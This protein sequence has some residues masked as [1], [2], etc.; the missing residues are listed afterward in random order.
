[1]TIAISIG[2]LTIALIGTGFGVYVMLKP[3][4]YEI[5]S[6]YESDFEDDD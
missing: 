1:M 5:F 4:I 3:L 2:I 6:I